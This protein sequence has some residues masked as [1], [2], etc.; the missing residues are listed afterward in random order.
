MNCVRKNIPGVRG[1]LDL[2][3]FFV[4]F[5]MKNSKHV[6]EKRGDRPTWLIGS[7]CWMLTAKRAYFM[8]LT[9][10]FPMNYRS[11]STSNI[12]SLQ[13]GRRKRNPFRNELSP[14]ANLING[15]RTWQNN[16]IYWLTYVRLRSNINLITQNHK[17]ESNYFVYV[18]RI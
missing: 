8:K 3:Y 17:Y 13:S 5:S 1:I 12:G 4:I 18:R 9:L 11:P 15:V 14:F 10:L 2:I 7:R 6:T 16:S